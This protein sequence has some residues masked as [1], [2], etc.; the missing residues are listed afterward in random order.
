ML[1]RLLA[2]LFILGI[3]FPIFGEIKGDRII[4]EISVI[5]NHVLSASELKMLMVTRKSPWY[6][7]LPWV[8]SLKFDPVVLKAELVRLTAWY[9]DL[10]YYEVVIDTMVDRSYVDKVYLGLRIKEGKVVR[11]SRV[12]LEGMLSIKNKGSSR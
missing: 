11:V 5:G 7:W 3:S 1:S 10:G 12:S 2:V 6:D 4:Q 8:S 9:K